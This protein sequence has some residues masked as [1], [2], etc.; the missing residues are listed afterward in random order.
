MLSLVVSLSAL[1]RSAIHIS[2]I[3][4]TFYHVI[5]TTQSHQVS[6]HWSA[7]ASLLEVT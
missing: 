4:I 2:K 3:K 7:Q 5:P 1:S 6:L